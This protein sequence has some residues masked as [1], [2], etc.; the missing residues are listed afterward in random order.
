MLEEA[1]GALELMCSTRM[2]FV[3]PLSFG[4]CTF[5]SEQY[6]AADAHTVVDSQGL[7]LFDRLEVVLQLFFLLSMNILPAKAIRMEG[8]K[9]RLGDARNVSRCCVDVR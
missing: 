1:S 4:V 5:L 7:Q 8:K 9:R 2:A 3:Y 6:K